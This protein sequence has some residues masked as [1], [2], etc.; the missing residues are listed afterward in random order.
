MNLGTCDVGFDLPSGVNEIPVG[1]G[2]EDAV[3]ASV[4]RT[5]GKALATRGRP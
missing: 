1:E 4:R 2:L 5:R 3:D